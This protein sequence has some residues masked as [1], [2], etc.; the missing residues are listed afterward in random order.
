LLFLV[1]AASIAIACVAGRY[2]YLVDV[3]AGIFLTLAI[4]AVVT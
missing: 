4:W 1:L 3:V 2:H